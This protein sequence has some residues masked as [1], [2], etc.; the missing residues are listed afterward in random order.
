VDQTYDVFNRWIRR[1]TD[2]D[3][4]GS[5]SAVDT[6]FAGYDGITPT[7]QFNGSAAS[8]LD[9]RYVWHQA[10]DQILADE[11]VASLSSAGNTIWSLND[12]LGTPRDLADQN[13]STYTTTVTNHRTYASFGQR[14]AE[15]NSSVDLA[16]GF[17]GEPL[18]ED[19]GLQNNWFRWYDAIPSHWL[20]DDPL[21]FWGGDPNLH[22]YV[23]NRAE[24]ATDPTGL[25]IPGAALVG[26]LVGA[27]YGAG[28]SLGVTIGVSLITTGQ[29]PSNG[30]M[31][32][33]IVGGAVAGG[34]MGAVATG[35][36]GGATLV[37]AGILAGAAAGAASS[38]AQQQIDHGTIDPKQVMVSAAVGGLAGGAGA[39]VSVGLGA[40][41]P[42]IL[43]PGA[44]GAIG[45]ALPGGGMMVIPVAST[46]SANGLAPALVTG[47]TSGFLTPMMMSSAGGGQ[48]GDASSG[49]SEVPPAPTNPLTRGQRLREYFDRLGKQPPSRTA[50]EAL[51]RIS[52]TLEEVEDALSGIPK[53]TPPP[54]PKMPDGRMYPPQPDKIV[55]NADGS[56]SAR[57]AGH[58]VEIGADGSITIR[59]IKTGEIDFHQPG[60]GGGE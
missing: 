46:V 50:D 19:T 38:A 20:S 47:V 23:F 48:G 5:A 14:T 36:V 57:T 35:D 25:F 8:N 7:L 30:Q 17:T 26:G 54:P 59:N 18:D 39:A 15:T 58:T 53:K 44:G 6:F 29:M 12:G 24:N 28:I 41:L 43:P 2:P 27:A 60:A 42:H 22:R 34:I 11:D 13:E 31:V 9:H 4:A 32:G 33:A 1:Q 3:G 10:I 37:T 49:D 16:F 52:R 56:I 51:G 21:G 40:A 55:R 45:A